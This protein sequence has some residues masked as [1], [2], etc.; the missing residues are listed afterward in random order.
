MVIMIRVETRL[1]P[2]IFYPRKVVGVFDVNSIDKEKGL[3][4]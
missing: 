1:I 3:K 2:A 4:S